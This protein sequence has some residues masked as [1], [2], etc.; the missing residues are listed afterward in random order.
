MKSDKFLGEFL[1]NY[2]LFPEKD[3]WSRNNMVALMDESQPK[4]DLAFVG[5]Q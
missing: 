5:K 2:R 3:K 4:R 1:K